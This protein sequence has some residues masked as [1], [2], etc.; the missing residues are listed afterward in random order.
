[1]EQLCLIDIAR[2]KKADLRNKGSSDV[3]VGDRGAYSG[4]ETNWWP[5]SGPFS[6]FWLADLLVLQTLLV[7]PLIKPE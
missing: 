4:G 7:Y 2:L 1:M 6:L 3:L 5:P